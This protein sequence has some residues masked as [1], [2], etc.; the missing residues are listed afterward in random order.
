NDLHLV[1]DE[2]AQEDYAFVRLAEVLGPARRNR[3]LGV[4]GVVILGA[5]GVHEVPDRQSFA[6][7]PGEADLVDGNILGSLGRHVGG[8]LGA[9][10]IGVEG[11]GVVHRHSYLGVAEGEGDWEYYGVADAS[12]GMTLIVTFVDAAFDDPVVGDI[13]ADL[14]VLPAL[15]GPP[16]EGAAL[17]L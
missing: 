9:V 1:A 17:A 16:V 4:P 15:F 12:V 8:G 11:V 3:A 6:V 10:V 7:H 13:E 5:L 2:T 14:D